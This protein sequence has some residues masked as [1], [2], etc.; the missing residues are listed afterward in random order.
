M[1]GRP[2]AQ[3]RR[4]VAG[5]ILS[6]FAVAVAG[7]AAMGW[8]YARDSPA[9]QGPI[10]LISVDGV[11]AAALPAYGARRTDTPAIDSLASEAVV[12]DR[13]YAHSPLMLPAHASLLTGQLPFDHG[14][15]DDAGFA[16]KRDAQTLAEMLR[17]RGFTT[18]AA[19]SSFLLRPES[20]VAQGFT[21][22][23]AE[24]PAGATDTPTLEREG[25]QT[26]EAAE[27]W[28]QTQDDRR[29]FLFV[30]V[31]QRDA[32]VAVTR[33]LSL[34]KSR[35]LYDQATVVLIGDRGD[36]AAGLTLD[37]ATLRIP[38]MV[39]QPDG[40]GAGRRVAALVQQIDLVPTILD[41]V[42]APVPGRLRGRSLRPVLDDA[43][44]ELDEQ[45][46]YSESLAAS[47]RFGGHPLFALTTAGFRYIRG[48]TEDLVSLRPRPAGTAAGEATEAGL[49]RRELDRL[50]ASAVV[51]RPEPIAASDEERY[52][53]F[54]Y[55]ATPRLIDAAPTFGA[56]EQPALVEEH[57]AAALLIGQKKYSA[58]IRALQRIARD[59]G[60]LPAVHYQIGM[61]LVR[62][63]RFEEAIDAFRKARDLQP[64]APDLALALADALMRAGQADLAQE[65]AEEAIVL[66]HNSS[67]EDRGAA[68]EMAARVALA[69][70][71]ADAASQYAEDAHEAHPA[72]PVR[73]FVSGRILYE[74]GHYA[75]AAA[76]FEG[77]VTASTAAEAIVPDLHLYL[78]ES[79][80][81]LDRYA[82]AEKHYREELRAFP[83]NVQAYASLAMLYRASNRDDAVEDVLNE[84]VSGTPTPEGYAVAARLWTILGERSRAEALRSDARARFRGDP[85]PAL[86]GRDVK[87]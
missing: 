54:G 79:L 84:L 50:L 19:V 39:K 2:P 32:D 66:A 26:I 35:E 40:A 5:L 38:W 77:A 17:T 6:L 48:A 46:V 68:Y 67:P 44:A 87:R 23:D 62:T 76:A 22:F 25:A 18:G 65:Q 83:R 61:L 7:A 53:L 13:A 28:V 12:F 9:H 82:D 60:G 57:R 73:E 33:L 1:P 20:G 43:D 69:R 34:L 15:R 86:L 58:G 63:G 45:P 55:L 30:Q 59:H 42:R 49:L 41:L 16:L 81:H 21:Y 47:Y 51:H 64:D 70:K 74:Q 31:D 71:D 85:L 56:A 8:W 36:P 80:V 4:W 27:R 11:P 10:V 3:P 14:V 78:A 24:L 37:D 29:F 75:D 52:A 72:R